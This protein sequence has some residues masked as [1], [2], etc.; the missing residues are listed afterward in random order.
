VK[1]VRLAPV[2]YAPEKETVFG[3]LAELGFEE[4]PPT[5][6]KPSNPTPKLKP[7]T[8]TPKPQTLNT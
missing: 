5:P 2:S 4:V 1:E 8:L 6:P 7:Q 3:S